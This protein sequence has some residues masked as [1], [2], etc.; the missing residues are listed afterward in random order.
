MLAYAATRHDVSAVNRTAVL[1]AF[2]VLA[3]GPACG[4]PQRALMPESRAL[5]LADAN[6]NR[7]SAG[8]LRRGVLRV[9]LDATWAGWRPDLD[10]D[11]AVS[12]QAFA[13]RGKTPSI[14]GP[15]L[16][17]PEGTEVR[18]SVRNLIA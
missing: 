16:R 2:V 8:V 4:R 18:V 17:V 10:V 11:S 3:A 14:P 6:D 9:N 1:L 7:T 13:E 5:A 15:L 12:V